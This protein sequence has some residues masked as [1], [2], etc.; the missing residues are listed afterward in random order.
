LLLRQRLLQ[1]ADSLDAVRFARERL[2]FDPDP[3]QE[4]LLRGR[5]RR[6]S[7]KLFAAV[8]EVDGSGGEGGA[9][10]VCEAGE[11]GVVVSPTAR[12]SGEFLRKAEG[13]VRKA[14]NPAARGWR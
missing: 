7:L 2:G 5:M 14:E 9:S 12:Q 10:R 4:L 8:G 11:P 1:C 13:F 3:K 6:G